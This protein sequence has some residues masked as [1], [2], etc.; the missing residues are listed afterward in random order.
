MGDRWVVIPPLV[1]WTKSSGQTWTFQIEIYFQ[2]KSLEESLKALKAR[3]RKS[4]KL[5]IEQS[6]ESNNI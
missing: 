1:H 6:R 4:D 2:M 5:Y 3:Y